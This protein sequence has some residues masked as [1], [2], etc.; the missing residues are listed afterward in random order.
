[1]P[2]IHTKR[3][4]N[5]GTKHVVVSVEGGGQAVV[6]IKSLARVERDED[7]RSERNRRKALRQGVVRVAKPYWKY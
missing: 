1:M 2:R 3:C 7:W 4:E 6:L 5:W